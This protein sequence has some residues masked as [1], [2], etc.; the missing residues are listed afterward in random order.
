MLASMATILSTNTEIGLNRESDKMKP[1]RRTL[2]FII[3]SAALFLLMSSSIRSLIGYALDLENTNASQILLIPFITGFLI[4]VDRGKIF[5]NVRWAR[6]PGALTLTAGVV[7][8]GVSRLWGAGLSDE[9][10]RLGLV[11]LSLIVLWIGGFILFYGTDAFKAALFP[12]LFL[13]FCLPIP[14]LI[15]DRTVT[16]LQ[17]ASADMA[18]GLLKLTGMPIYREDV[19]FTLPNPVGWVSSKPFIIEVARQCSGIR[20][21]ISLTVLTMLAGHMALGAWW[22]RAVLLIVGIPIIIFKNAVRIATLS[23]LA[24]HVDPRILTSRLHKEGG[25]PFFVVGLLLLYPVLKLLMNSER[26]RSDTQSITL[27]AQP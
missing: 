12:L 19:L 22:R 27:E 15:M 18:F 1:S 13:V 7:L 6:V 20:A 23:F 9:G 26:K 16:F 24:V 14:S 17:H 11:T 21:A 3:F 10:D 4:F 25:I 8:W 5:R 2:F